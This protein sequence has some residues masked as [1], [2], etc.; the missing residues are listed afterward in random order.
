M[1]AI[2][3]LIPPAFG[4]HASGAGASMHQPWS[5]GHFSESGKQSDS[6]ESSGAGRPGMAD[7]PKAG[8]SAHNFST[9]FGRN[10][11]RR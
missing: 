8:R 10:R 2:F 7:F 1:H 5:L 6:F 11:I 9:A 4:G 3:K